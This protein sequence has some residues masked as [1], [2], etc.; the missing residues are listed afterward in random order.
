MG[1]I[2]NDHQIVL[3]ENKAYSGFRTPGWML[4]TVDVTSVGEKR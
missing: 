2:F 3:V 1:D 4:M